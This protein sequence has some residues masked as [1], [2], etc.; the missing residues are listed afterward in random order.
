MSRLSLHGAAAF[1]LAGLT[2]CFV[3]CGDDGDDGA[4]TVSSI[5]ASIGRINDA[6]CECESNLAC[7]EDDS[8]ELACTE[9]V[10]KRHAGQLGS[11]LTCINEGYAELESCI[12]NAS[13]DEAVTDMCYEQLDLEELC[14]PI[15]AAIDEAIEDE[16]DI[17]CPYDIEC[18]DGSSALGNYCD[19]VAECQDASDEDFCDDGQEFTCLDGEQVS[20]S[21]VCDGFADCRDGS[22][23]NP[24]QCGARN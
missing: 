21:W 4:G 8:A 7:D 23:E 14:E 16:V 24:T 20:A 13:C 18:A 12:T 9:R 1:A 3:A 2:S 5:F 11:I 19:G 17:E 22:D 6:R 10:V 15:P